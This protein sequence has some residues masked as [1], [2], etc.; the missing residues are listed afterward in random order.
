MGR[1]PGD[2]GKMG[3]GNKDRESLTPRTDA[4]VRRSL[5]EGRHIFLAF[6]RRRVGTNEAEDVFQRFAVRALES[7]G[8]LRDIRSLR[9]WLSR[10]LMSTLVDHLRQQGRRHRREQLATESEHSRRWIAKGL[11]VRVFDQGNF[12]GQGPATS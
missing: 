3:G 10:I 2:K 8:N 7:S 1:L 11:L 6:L 4:A 9:T 12:C 5:I